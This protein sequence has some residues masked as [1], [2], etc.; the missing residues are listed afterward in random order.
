MQD[1]FITLFTLKSIGSDAFL[2]MLE[3]YF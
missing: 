2:V 3:N 1:L